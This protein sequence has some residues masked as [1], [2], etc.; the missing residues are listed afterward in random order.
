MLT[1]RLETLC[2]KEIILGL[3]RIKQLLAALNNP[4]QDLKIIH[5]AGTNGKGSTCA[6]LQSILTAANY[7][8]GLFTSP[9]IDQLNEYFN[10]NQQL[11]SDQQLEQLIDRVAAIIPTLPDKP[12]IF[13]LICA[14]AFKY[15]QDENCDFVILEVGLGG[16]FDATNIITQPLVSLICKLALD[17]C[18][19]LGTTIEE[20]AQVKGGI[21]KENSAC[22]CLNQSPKVIDIIK[23]ICR[24]KQSTFAIA[25]PLNLQVI[26]Q[27]LRSTEFLLL[28]DEINLTC[29]LIGAYQQENL[30]LVLKTC[31]ILQ[32]Q[33]YNIPLSALIKGLKNTIWPFRFEVISQDPLIIIDGAHNP[34]GINAFCQTAAT[35][36][37]QRKFVFIIRIMQDK[38]I[39]DMIKLLIPYAKCFI[40]TQINDPR[41]C[42]HLKL[43][44]IIKAHFSGTVFSYANINDALT[45]SLEFKDPLCVIGSLA[46]AW[47]IRDFYQNR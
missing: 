23:T 15:F 10:L 6:M 7:K 32:Q 22:V 20:I 31:E 28:P 19:Y 44:K 12:S 8:V 16:E 36:L 14:L 43:K 39:E 34:D 17:H 13:E 27:D 30:A 40:A 11:I 33:N 46:A 37:P 42:D 24:K 26:K 1:S 41:A 38:A 45:K 35:L 25:D 18:Q 21:I 47:Q 9:A 29:P 5:V 4:E 3:E 2:S